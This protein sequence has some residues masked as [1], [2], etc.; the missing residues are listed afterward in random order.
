MLIL[1]KSTLFFDIRDKKLFFFE[2]KERFFLN[3]HI[4]RP[5]FRFLAYNS[6]PKPRRATIFYA[7]FVTDSF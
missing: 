7:I 2:K 6:L 3:Y 5:V 1:S 4:F